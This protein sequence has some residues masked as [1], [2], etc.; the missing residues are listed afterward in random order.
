MD[1][2]R[3]HAVALDAAKIHADVQDAAMQHLVLSDIGDWRRE[4]EIFVLNIHGEV[5]FMKIPK[6][7]S[8]S[9]LFT[10][11]VVS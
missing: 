9:F 11:R 2:A 3:I 5:K 8:L 6:N 1:A 7:V 4:G 10:C